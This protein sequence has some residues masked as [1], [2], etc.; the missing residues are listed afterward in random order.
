MVLL[1]MVLLYH[2]DSLKSIPIIK[3]FIKQE[4]KKMKRILSVIMAAM[5]CLSAGWLSIVQLHVMAADSNLPSL[6]VDMTAENH[7][8]LHGSAGF[9]YGISNEGVP[10]VNTLTPLKPK[11]LATKGALGTEHP[12]GD[13]LDVAEE[14]FEA[15]GEQVQMYTSNYYGVFGVTAD[16]N[17]YGGV[18]KKIIAP[19][20][21]EWKDEIRDRYPDV[22]SRIVYIPIN[23]GTPANV[24]GGYNFNTAWK[25][26]YDAIKAADPGAMIAGPNDAVYR[27]YS[28]MKDFLNYCK[29]NNCLP[30]IV[31]WHEL[32]V[33]CLDTMDDH[34]ADYRGICRELDIE[35]KQVVINEYAD[36]ADC[37][38]PGR[39]VNWIARLEEN[40]VYGC[41]PFWHQANNLNDLAADANQGNGAWQVYKWYGDMSGKTLDLHAENTTFDGFY[42]LASIDENKRSATVL[43]GGVDGEASVVLENIDDTAVFA[44]ADRVNVKVEASYFTGYHGAAY[45]PETVMEGI[46]PI[47]DGKVEINLN[48]TLFSAAYN[49]TVTE[50]TDPVSSPTVGSYR[51]VYEA[52]DAMLLGNLIIDLQNSPLETP[53]YFCSGGKRVGGIDEYGDGIEYSISVPIDGLYK[54]SFIYG[55]GV[56]STRNNA[57]TH[58]PLNVTQ[59]LIIDGEERPLLLPNTLFYS[60]EGMAEEYIDLTAGRHRISVMYDG[61]AGGFHDVLYVA[62][63][64]AYGEKCADFN[65]IYQ[66]ESADFNIFAGETTV[67]TETEIPMYSGN[68]YV[69][70]LDA[71][72]VED[73]GGIRWIVDVEN[74]GYYYLSFRH[75]APEGGKLRVYLDNTNLTYSNLAAEI[76]LP[77]SNEWTD[78]HATVFLRRGINIVDIDT[79][80]PTSVDYMRVVWANQDNSRIFEAEDAEGSFETAVAAGG[81]VYVTEMAG[82][83]D[84]DSYMELTVTAAEAGL[85]K[86]QVFQSNNDLCGTHDYNIKIIDRYATFEVNGDRDNAKRYFFPNTFSDDTFMERTIPITLEAGENKI[87]IYND[88]SWQVLWGGST[89]TPGTNRLE[90]FTPNFDK[91]IIS[92]ATVDVDMGEIAYPIKLS[93]TEGGYIYCDKNAAFH[94]ETATI[95]LLPDGRA[96]KLT[97]NGEDITSL[98]TTDDGSLYTAEIAVTGDTEV[99]AEFVPAMEGDYEKPEFPQ[100]GSVVLD[101]KRYKIIGEN[102]FSNGDFSD[103]SGETMEQWYVGANTSGHPSSGGY[104]PPKI[105]ED[106]SLE[107]LTPLS[108]SGLLIKNAYEPSHGSNVFYFGQDNSRPEGLKHYL[109]EAVGEPWTSNAWNGA[110]SLLAFVPIKSD[111]KYYFRFNAYTVSGAASVRWGAVNMNS[112]IPADYA[113]NGSL[114]FSGSGYMNCT[115]GNRQ[116]VGGGWT[117]HEGVIDSGDGDYFLFNAYWLQMAEY[118]CMGGFE[119]YELSDR[120]MVQIDEIKNPSTLSRKTGEELILAEAAEAVDENGEALSLPITWLNAEGVNADLPGVYAVTGY[121][122][123][124]DGYYYDGE[125]FVR[126]RIV[127]KAPLLPAEITDVKMEDGSLTVTI[128]TYESVSGTLYAALRHGG[129]LDEVYSNKLSLSAGEAI[130]LS[131]TIDVTN[132]GDEVSLYFW[133]SALSPLSEVRKYII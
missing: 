87:K 68:G 71:S 60:M 39:L 55:N 16:A 70:G 57:N 24:N 77:A 78:A 25:V 114:N 62:Y 21:A 40:Q 98:L 113:E 20:V 112:Y 2:R 92:P 56:G 41:L 85:Y 26:Y 108:D 49:I 36:F 13:A 123:L 128:K 14:F 45:E 64:G 129:S 109:V 72:P 52:E 88:D 80:S 126:Q 43:C 54:L 102:L 130:E 122:T 9:L 106:G 89:S 115:N 118:L 83:E 103:N 1:I 6:V 94:G 17:D 100:D 50:T 69:T 38:V 107:N 125:L 29:N 61:E 86:M 133:D 91:F 10:D 90:N 7:E 93:S 65:K 97:L 15:G 28:S 66:A 110:H 73:G 96:E 131:L 35:E 120:P 53:R 46:F 11:V 117:T 48:N 8:I 12:Y 67:R 18:L 105:N 63:A 44:D 37:G 23:E 33:G 81:E 27:G 127:V 76:E 59:K 32:Q 84:P 42:G 95:Y 75:I 101:G 31:T 124:P 5:L 111:T 4:E 3:I 116:N 19:A 58:R 132:D 34:I 79:D 30:D 74:S 121:V 47:V 51:A 22:D 104:L 82:A 99:F 119:L